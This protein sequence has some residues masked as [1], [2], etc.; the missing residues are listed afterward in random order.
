MFRRG[1]SNLVRNVLDGTEEVICHRGTHQ[2]G[3]RGIFG[4][5]ACGLAAL[6]FARVIF[7]KVRKSVRDED[8]LRAVIAKETV[9]VSL[10]SIIVVTWSSEQ[11]LL[12]QD[13]TDIC[14]DWSRYAL[15]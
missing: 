13:I 8:L 1:Q 12:H 11:P 4:V 9:Q 7:E 6:N 5:S 14:A 3:E 10:Y 15:A 2:Y